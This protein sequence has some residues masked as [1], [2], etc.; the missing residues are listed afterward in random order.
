M[1]FTNIFYDF[2]NEDFSEF[3]LKFRNPVKTHKSHDKTKLSENP[4]M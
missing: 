3:V 4:Q 2:S 1:V